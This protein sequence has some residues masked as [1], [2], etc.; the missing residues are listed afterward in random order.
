MRWGANLAASTVDVAEPMDESTSMLW[1]AQTNAEPPWLVVLNAARED[2]PETLWASRFDLGAVKTVLDSPARKKTIEA[3]VRGDSTVW[4][5]LECGDAMRDEAAVDTLAATLKRLETSL[6]SSISITSAVAKPGIPLRFAFSLVRVTRNDPAEEFFV[7]LL[8]QGERFHRGKPA[9]FPVFGRGRSLG[10]LAGKHLDDEFILDA[11][12][13]ITGPCTNGVKETKP[14]KDILLCVQWDSILEEAA[15]PPAPS[16]A[17]N[18][19]MVPLP[20]PGRLPL[21]NASPSIDEAV[22]R[23]PEEN[24][25][26]AALVMIGLVAAATLVLWRLRRR[27]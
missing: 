2:T 4:V 27:S 3:L 11:C 5:L 23:P 16:V 9:A 10:A 21:T 26:R 20:P 12:S 8:S 22:A 19:A 14:G 17:T 18:A 1:A 25:S 24:L 6:Q 7:N 15:R 13:F